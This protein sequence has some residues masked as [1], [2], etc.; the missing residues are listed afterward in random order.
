MRRAAI[1]VFSLRE[2]DDRGKRERPERFGREEGN[3]R[4]RFLAFPFPI[5]LDS[6]RPSS[7]M[8]T[9]TSPTQMERSTAR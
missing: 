4:L 7:N 5:H 3:G 9:V 1:S 8:Q 2:G 6:D